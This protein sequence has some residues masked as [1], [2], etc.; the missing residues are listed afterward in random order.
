M[1]GNP[2]T[3]YYRQPKIY[4]QLPSNGEFY[5]PGALDGDPSNISVFGMTAMDEIMLKT[6]DA[7]F[8]GEAVVQ[9]INSCLPV[10]KDP[11][12]IPQIDI[13]SILVALRIATYGEKMPLEFK[14]E[15]CGA[16]ND[17]E[18]DLS[19]TLDY[20]HSIT[21]ESSINIADL[22]VHFVPLNYRQQTQIA[23]DTYQ[24]QRKLYQISKTENVTKQN[25]ILNEI[26]KQLNQIQ[27]ASFRECI[28]QVDTKTESITNNVFI[29]NWLDNSDKFYYDKIKEHLLNMREKWTVPQQECKCS[30]CEHPTMVK[31]GFDNANFFGNP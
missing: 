18:L 16:D 5:P 14:C 21:F 25:E 1:Q 6:P 4:L 17:I 11:W 31:V 22:T 20:F 28:T 27:M 13:D 10:I 2:L 19:K 9:V 30:S 23:I 3:Q 7:L 8:T 29:S 26:T 12:V 24:L 15:K